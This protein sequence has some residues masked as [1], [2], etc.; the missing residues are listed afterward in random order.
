M[1]RPRPGAWRTA[2][3]ISIQLRRVAPLRFLCPNQPSHGVWHADKASDLD[4]RMSSM[5]G[6][7]IIATD[8][9][10]H[11]LHRT[12]RTLPAVT[13]AAKAFLVCIGMTGK[14]PACASC[15]NIQAYSHPTHRRRSSRLRARSF[16]VVAGPNPALGSTRHHRQFTNFRRNVLLDAGSFVFAT[17]KGERPS[18]VRSWEGYSVPHHD[19]WRVLYQ[20]LLDGVRVHQLL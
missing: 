20:I 1:E 5:G 13:L 18:V 7:P 2:L 15:G 8:R 10:R 6:R 3:A 16:S 19:W 11:I 17:W 9:R 14:K 12:K 4:R